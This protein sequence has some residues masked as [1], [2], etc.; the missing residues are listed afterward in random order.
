MLTRSFSNSRL[1]PLVAGDVLTFLSL[2]ALL[3]G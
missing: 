2:P 3:A 1:L